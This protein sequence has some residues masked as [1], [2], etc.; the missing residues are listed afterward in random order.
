MATWTAD[1]KRW[2]CST[3]WS[4]TQGFTPEELRFV[5]VAGTIFGLLVDITLLALFALLMEWS[6][7]L[8]SEGPFWQS[9]AITWQGETL[10]RVRPWS[11]VLLLA[12]S[13]GVGTVVALV[14]RNRS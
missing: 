7:A 10:L 12:S 2:L 9:L 11:L 13:F 8:D 5:G 6:A 3:Q 14:L 4:R 1:Q